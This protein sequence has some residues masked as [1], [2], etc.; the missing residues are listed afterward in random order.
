MR[1]A[2][3]GEDG[4]PSRTRFRV[5]ERFA[6]GFTWLELEPETGRQHQIRVH[7][8]SIGHPLAVDEMYR[9]ASQRTMAELG[10]QGDEVVLARTPLHCAK[11]VLP[12]GA[13]SV[14][15]EAPLQEDLSGTLEVLRRAGP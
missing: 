10:G 15:V 4:K 9:S 3:P 7:L 2:A 8:A 12:L 13:R 5:L 14:T 1:P 11:L 6:A